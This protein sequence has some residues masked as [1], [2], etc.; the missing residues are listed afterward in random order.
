MVLVAHRCREILVIHPGALGDVLQAVPALTALRAFDGGNRLTF[1]GQT[2][3]GRFFVGTGLADRALSFD[4]LGLE[5]LFTR[6][7]LPPLLL[8]RFSRFD[9]VVSWFGSC[10]EPFPK[11]LRVLVPEALVSLP[12][13]DSGPPPAVWEHLLST[14]SPWGVTVP[15]RF[16]SLSLPEA[17]RGEARRALAGLGWDGRQ[18]LLV[19]HPGAG[20]ASK[21]WPAEGF[22][23]V[24]RRVVSETGCQ[25]LVHEGPADS[26]AVE[27]QFRALDLPTLHLLEPP[28]HLLAAVLQAASAYLG[29]DSGVSH[30]AAATGAPAVILFSRTTRGRWAP[31][32]PTAL[33]LTVSDS[34]DDDETIA[35]AVSERLD[36]A[37][38]ERVRPASSSP[39]RTRPALWRR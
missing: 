9:R 11:R 14:L 7:P 26:A 39:G 24:I 23:R 17:W 18:P 6:E 34:S 8:S 13:P 16:A 25:V 19:V 31:W 35:Q 12:V 4:G 1:A 38:K 5:A 10:A 22:A 27:Q 36:K 3:L 2:R 32:S 21:R 30:L 33:P 15:P 28:L 20:G 37:R 29:A